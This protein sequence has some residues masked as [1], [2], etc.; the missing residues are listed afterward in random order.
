MKKI[1]TETNKKFIM[2]EKTLQKRIER[3][4]QCFVGSCIL[5]QVIGA[6]DDRMVKWLSGLLKRYKQGLLEIIK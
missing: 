1:L 6:P 2:E 3:Y 4:H 5:G